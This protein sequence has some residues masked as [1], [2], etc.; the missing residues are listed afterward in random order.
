[1][2]A[3]KRSQVERVSSL[4]QQ[5]GIKRADYWTWDR[6]LEQGYVIIGSPTTVAEKLHE[7][8]TT[9]NVGHLMVLLQ[10]GNMSKEVSH[11]NTDLFA[12]HVIPELHGLFDDQWEDHWS[13][14]PLPRDLRAVRDEAFVS[15][16]LS[17]PAGIAGA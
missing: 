13:P 2:R 1:V 5:Q 12:R 17:V 3:G 6:M 10:F 11:L 8:A 7:V 4:A 14:K 9:L 15:S 16:G